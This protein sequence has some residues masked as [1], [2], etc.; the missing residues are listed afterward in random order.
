MPA[1]D[2]FRGDNKLLRECIKA[3][4]ELNDSNSLVPHGIGGHAR[5]LLSACYRRLPNHGTQL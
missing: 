2:T 4:I 1:R 5:N 3:L